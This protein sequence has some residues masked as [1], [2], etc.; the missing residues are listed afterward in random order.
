MFG[1]KGK[2]KR[3]AYIVVVIA[4]IYGKLTLCHTPFLILQI[5]YLISIQSCEV[6][7]TLIP[8]LERNK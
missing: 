2:R 8:N 4:G 1:Q 5:Y 3:W 7:A 6:G